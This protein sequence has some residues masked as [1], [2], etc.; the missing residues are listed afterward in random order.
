MSAKITTFDDAGDVQSI[1]VRV[2]PL[3]VGFDLRR[4]RMAVSI[5]EGTTRA[6][7]ATRKDARFVVEGTTDEVIREFT[8][9]GYRRVRAG[10]K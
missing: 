2:A 9:H 7:Y 6:S 5:P 1:E 8:R 10:G 4:Q 3:D